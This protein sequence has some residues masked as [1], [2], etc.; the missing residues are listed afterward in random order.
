MNK[1]VLTL[2]VSALLAG[3]WTTLDAKVVSV[4]PTIGGTYL[5]GTGVGDNTVTNLLKPGDFTSDAT[6]SVNSN[7]EAWVLEDAGEGMFYL[8]IAEGTNAG[9]YLAFYDES[10]GGTNGDFLTYSEETTTAIKFKFAE[11]GGIVV[12]EEIGGDNG[13]F[14]VNDPFVLTASGRAKVDFSNRTDPATPLTFAVYGSNDNAYDGMPGLDKIVTDGADVN[15]NSLAGNITV[16]APLNILANGIYLSVVTNDNGYHIL[17]TG[18]K[19]IEADE[20]TASNSLVASWE[21]QEGKLVSTASLRTENVP[22]AYLTYDSESGNYGITYVE[23]QAT[24]FAEDKA[25]IENAT[26]SVSATSFEGKE[27][28][29]VPTT[30]IIEANPINGNA[31]EKLSSVPSGYAVVCL[32]DGTTNYYLKD[33]GNGN[34]SLAE[35]FTA[36]DYKDFLWS[37]SR[38]GSGDVFNYTFTNLASGK[39]WSNGYSTFVGAGDISGLTLTL[40]NGNIGVSSG[41]I[42]YNATTK[43]IVSFYEAPTAAKTLGELNAIYNPGF[44]MTIKISKDGKETIEDVDKFSG[45]LYPV[46]AYSGGKTIVRIWDNDEYAAGHNAKMLVLDKTTKVGSDDNSNVEGSFKWISEKE[47]NKNKD[48]YEA[49]FQ[50]LY[51]LSEGKNDGADIEWVKVGNSYL[52]ILSTGNNRYQLTTISYV[53]DKTAQPY[54]VLQSNNVVNV[55]TLLGKYLTFS[56]VNNQDLAQDGSEEYKLNGILS[57]ANRDNSGDEADYVK[58]S[59]VLANAPE[60]Q[61]V[62]TDANKSANTFTIT[63]READVE[64]TNVTLRNNNDGTYTLYSADVNNDNISADVVKMTATTIVGTRHMDGFMDAKPGE[65]R[66]QVFHIGQYH[67]ETGNSTAFWTENHQSN[68]S[69]QLGVTTSEENAVNW[70]LAIQMQR[71]EDDLVTADADTIYITRN[72]ASLNSAGNIVTNEVADTLAILQYT[73]QNQGNLEYVIYNEGNNLNYYQCQ[74]DYSWDGE[75]VWTGDDDNVTYP[76]VRFALKMKP[77]STYNII[78]IDKSYNEEAEAVIA[79]L[80]DKKVYVANSEQWG[81][82]KHMDLYAADNNSLMQ[83]LPVDRPEYR[84]IEMVWG[85]T[86]KLWRNENESQV[87]YEKRDDKSIVNDETLSFL[88]IDNDNQFDMNPAIFADTAYINRWDADGVKN[89]CYQYLLAV[90]VENVSEYFCP[91]TPEHNTDAWREANGGPCPDAKKSAYVEGRF[92][93]NLIDTANVYGLTHLHNNPYINRT[94]EGNDCAKLSFVEGVHAGDTLYLFRGNG[95]TIKLALDTPDFNVAKFAFKYEDVEEGSF[96]IQ[97]Q[98][99]KYLAPENKYTEAKD[100]AEAYEDAAA[101]RNESMIS[102]EGYLRFVN[103][104]LVVDKNYQ[105]GDIFNMTERYTAQAPT[106]NEEISAENAAVSVVATD[107]A[108]IIKGAEGKNVV[109]ATILGKVVANETVNSDNETIAVPAGIAVV[110]VDGESFKVVVK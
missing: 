24:N 109:I 107:G 20:L 86:I 83:V 49:D 58:A 29:S 81:S 3:A 66:N 12:A 44:A 77:D 88:N 4:Q 39:A 97:T 94:E 40:S 54:I 65:L 45:T 87:V 95:D 32:Y 2:C 85:D 69:H 99:K 84:Q 28:A 13:K 59:S 25:G 36:A 21:W 1:K 46:A 48:N 90:D 103:G 26:I 108:V 41:S 78:P 6:G 72:L 91:L 33:D 55:T 23:S 56:F 62:I 15:V 18:D 11:N 10:N 16:E 27:Y 50:F 61:W 42:D 79:T 89:T 92:L 52:Y 73:F 22:T 5:I 71:D 70:K 38:S 43:A 37:V 35:N 63:N 74:E 93:V 47:Y 76:A 34:V 60:T 7:S 17:A 67:Y 51:S 31:L 104:C 105:K 96:K 53:N 80:T 101:E 106:A 57:V 68:R 110:S 82:V 102:N 98:W 14:L 8:Q 64:I 19:Q 9:Q 100:F 30:G 75:N